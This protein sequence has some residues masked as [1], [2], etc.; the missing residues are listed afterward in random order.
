MRRRGTRCGVFVLVWDAF[1]YRLGE[2]GFDAAAHFHLHIQRWVDA[3]QAR[4]QTN[5]APARATCSDFRWG[6]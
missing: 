6:W 4:V 2:D 1:N 3:M 5:S